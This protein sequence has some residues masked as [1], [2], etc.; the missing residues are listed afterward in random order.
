LFISFL[1]FAIK[2][3]KK[4]NQRKEKRTLRYIRATAPN[5]VSSLCDLVDEFAHQLIGSLREGLPEL[6]AGR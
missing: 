6:A 4:Q 1:V 2:Q 5:P 3:E